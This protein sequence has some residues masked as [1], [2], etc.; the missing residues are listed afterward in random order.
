MHWVTKPLTVL[1]LA[2][3]SL[4]CQIKEVGSACPEMEVPVTA[5]TSFEADAERARGPESVEFNVRFGCDLDPVCIVTLGDD[6]AY[7][8]QECFGQAQCPDGFDCLPVMQKGPFEGRQFCVWKECSTH[9][10]CG[11]PW[12]LE[13][14]VVKELSLGIDNEVKVCRFRN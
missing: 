10:D 8:S 7:C 5:K 6:E 11:D 13:C 14:V 12:L 9:A 1:V 4:A 2:V 3:G